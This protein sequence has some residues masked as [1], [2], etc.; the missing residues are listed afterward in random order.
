MSST[1]CE[2]YINSVCMVTKYYVCFQQ[3]PRITKN[4]RRGVQDDIL[5][6]RVEGMF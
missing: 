5:L 4:A 2:Q 1:P 3:S 6:L